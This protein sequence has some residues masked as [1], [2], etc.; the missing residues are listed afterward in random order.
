M[1]EK[2]EL[3]TGL[4]LVGL[5]LDPAHD[6]GIGSQDMIVVD[7]EVEA[8]ETE[9]EEKEKTADHMGEAEAAVPDVK[10]VYS[11]SVST[12]TMLSPMFYSSVYL[13]FSAGSRNH[14]IKPLIRHSL[15]YFAISAVAI[16]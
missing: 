3:T 13:V 2:K 8:E 4:H 5:D 1:I 11:I 16:I 12:M 15:F 9:R 6:P 10:S 7:L 14:L